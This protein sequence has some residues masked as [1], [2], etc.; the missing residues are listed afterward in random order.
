MRRTMNPSL[1]KE[2]TEILIYAARRGADGVFAIDMGDHV[3]LSLSGDAG[4]RLFRAVAANPKLY[5]AALAQLEAFDYMK[6]VDDSRP[7]G[8]T[9]LTYVITATGRARVAKPAQNSN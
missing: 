7:Q 9:D 4:S 1:T 2:Q 3:R 8:S 6:L 5:A